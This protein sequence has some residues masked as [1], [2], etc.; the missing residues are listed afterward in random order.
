M[1]EELLKLMVERWSLPEDKVKD[2]LN[3]VWREAESP[4]SL[5]DLRSATAN[6]LQELILKDNP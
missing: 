6:Y 1:T 2:F 5:E 3:E 4:V